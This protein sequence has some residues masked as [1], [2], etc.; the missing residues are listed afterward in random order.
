MEETHKQY[1]D[2]NTRNE[3]NLFLYTVSYERL[4][5]CDMTGIAATSGIIWNDRI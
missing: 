2:G 4:S 1:Y 5:V 3:N